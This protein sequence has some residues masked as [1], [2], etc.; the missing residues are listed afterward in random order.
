MLRRLFST[1][2]SVLDLVLRVAL[3]AV[4]L[5]HGAQ[6]VLG[7]FGGYGYSATMDF[8]TKAGFPAALAFLAIMAESL[9]ALGLLFGLLTRVAAFGLFCEMVVAVA[10]VHARQGFFMNWGGTMPAGTEGFEYHI[11]ALALL[12]SAIVRGAGALSLDRW[13]SGRFEKP[14]EAAPASELPRSA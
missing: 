7:W 1:S 5:P 8:F 3:A 14:R 2:D 6:K 10:T 4:Y 11:L 13:I 9:G 12:L